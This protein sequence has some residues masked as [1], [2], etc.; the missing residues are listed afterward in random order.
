MTALRA[1]S[2]ADAPMP[3]GKPATSLKGFQGTVHS[4]SWTP[5]GDRLAVGGFDGKVRIYAMPKG[6]EVKAFVPVPLTPAT[7]VAAGK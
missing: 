1:A 3:D 2:A 5:K 6:E 7:Q 4:L